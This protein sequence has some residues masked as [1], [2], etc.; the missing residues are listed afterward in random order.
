MTTIK[1]EG[2]LRINKQK[3]NHDL[4]PFKYREFTSAD[5]HKKDGNVNE[6]KTRKVKRMKK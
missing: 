2:D 3:R 4:K 1:W 5:K 6:E